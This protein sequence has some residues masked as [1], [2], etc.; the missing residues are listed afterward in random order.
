MTGKNRPIIVKR[1]AAH[2]DEHGGQ[3]KVAYADFVTAMMA[4]FLIMW[5][6]SSVSSNDR[7]VI[8]KYFTSTSL[9]E[10][11]AGNGVLNGGRSVMEG[12]DSRSTRGASSPKDAKSK[13]NQSREG[14]S[15]QASAASPN[16]AETQRLEALK[17]ELEQMM[18]AGQMN[19]AAAHVDVTITSEGLRIQIFDRDGEPMFAP[20]ASEPLPRLK[21]ILAVIAEVLA[22]V[23]NSIVLSGHTDGQFFQR[24]NYSNWELSADRANAVRRALESDGLAP[25]R[26]VQIEGRAASDPLLPQTPLDP[27]N[28][29]IAVTLLRSDLDRSGHPPTVA[30]PQPASPY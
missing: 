26:V 13:D 2:D 18:T 15:S 23:Q 16:R 5:L 25:G 30:S 3:W 8:A 22:T 9:F 6:L 7:E 17:A 29:R 10:M 1:V 19:S 20:G 21:A 11:P 27:R 12:A 14:H 4:F 24:N 28:R